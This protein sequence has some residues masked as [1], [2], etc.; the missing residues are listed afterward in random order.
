MNRYSEPNWAL[1]LNRRELI[2]LSTELAETLQACRDFLGLTREYQLGHT[3][4][5]VIV[6]QAA[7]ALDKVRP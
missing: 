2:D 4:A 1:P 6:R 5:H 7:A 3:G